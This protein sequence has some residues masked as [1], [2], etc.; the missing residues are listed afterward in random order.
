MSML[1]S[2]ADESHWAR[3]DEDFLRVT[4]QLVYSRAAVSTMAQEPSS[5]H[6]NLEGSGDSSPAR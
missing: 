3:V 4:A 1:E 6:S 5:N 2:T